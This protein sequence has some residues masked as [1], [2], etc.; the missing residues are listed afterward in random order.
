L[1]EQI[2]NLLELLAVALFFLLLLN[3]LLIQTNP[4]V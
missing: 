3:A 2:L 4:D 1:L